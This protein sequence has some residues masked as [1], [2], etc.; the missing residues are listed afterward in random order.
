MCRIEHRPLILC[1]CSALIGSVVR[2]TTTQKAVQDS[3]EVLQ[4]ATPAGG[5][6]QT[7]APP[8]HYSRTGGSAIFGC[9]GPSNPTDTRSLQTCRFRRDERGHAAAPKLVHGRGNALQALPLQRR[10]SER[11]TCLP[12][13]AVAC[14]RYCDVAFDPHDFVLPAN[15]FYTG[16]SQPFACRPNSARFPRLHAHWGY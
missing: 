3:R 12:R 5:A 15:R 16:F 4:A 13:P 14:R 6:T 7:H 9:F 2:R 8:R 10:I 1:L 11:T